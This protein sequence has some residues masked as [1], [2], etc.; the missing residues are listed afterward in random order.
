MKK[1]G[2]ED[3]IYYQLLDEWYGRVMFEFCLVFK[4]GILRKIY[5][6][7]HQREDERCWILNIEKELP[8]WRIKYF[9]FRSFKR[10]PPHIWRNY[11]CKEHKTIGFAIY[12]PDNTNCIRF[13][14]HFG[15]HL[16]IIFERC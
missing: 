12:P 8:D 10:D 9:S 1:L 16:D 13:E 2:I 4:R 15:D 14:P 7:E 11:W 5:I 3:K 6:F